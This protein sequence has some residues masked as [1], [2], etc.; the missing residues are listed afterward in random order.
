[1]SQGSSGGT[2]SFAA[3]TVVVMQAYDLESRFREAAEL[4]RFALERARLLKDARGEARIHVE[5]G[6]VLT[7][8]LSRDTSLDAAE[9]LATHHRSRQL[10]E[11]LGDPGVL[12]AALDAEGFHLYWDKL[13][14]GTGEWEPIEARFVRA[15][16]LAE[17]AKDSRGV[18]E[19]LFHL[20][21]THQFRGNAPQAQEAYER[22]L[23]VARE[24]ADAL[25]QSY[26][27]RHLADLAEQR[28]DLDAA[29]AGHRECLRLREQ[30]GFR[31]GTVY[32]LLALA[33]VLTL[34]EPQSDEALAAIQRALRISEEQK[35]PTGLRESQAALGRIHA[36]RKDAG[37]ALALFE[38]AMASAEHHQDWLTVVELLLDIARAHALQGDKARVE[39]LVRRA[40]A[41][42]TE[43]G[44]TAILAEVEQLGR[45]HGIALR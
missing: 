39:S 45:E 5:L 42:T 41:L 14:K 27:L 11:A 1:M 3:S 25:M 7:R 12:A 6:R 13:V 34:R 31:T 24:S 4:G 17:E 9:V 20:G 19:A 22:S 28:G 30:V 44:L 18:S 26:S 40:H 32:A 35:D 36:G 2:A 16:A 33:H 8:Q 38:K 29:L 21:L 43:R 23:A 10:A 15:R 37:A